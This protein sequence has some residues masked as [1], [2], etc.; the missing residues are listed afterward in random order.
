[1]SYAAAAAFQTAIY[2]TLTSNDALSGV[3]VVDAI[4]SGGASSTFVLIGPEDIR[5]ASDKTGGGAEHNFDVSV[6]SN[7]QGFLAAK[8]VA[9]AVSGA[10]IGQRPS[11]SVGRI[12]SINLKKVKAR[13]LDDGSARRID[14]TF[15]ARVEL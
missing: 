6:I 8:T 13:R 3:S 4:P 10:L 7:A 9:A 15:R 5:N 1:M 11:M 2:T 14:M 12:I